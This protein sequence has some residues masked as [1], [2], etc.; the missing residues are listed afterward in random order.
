METNPRRR[1]PVGVTFQVMVS[2]IPSTY[3]QTYFF[4]FA[5]QTENVLNCLFCSGGYQINE[6]VDPPTAFWLDPYARQ[7][8]ITITALKSTKHF[9]RWGN[10]PDWD[11][12]NKTERR[13]ALGAMR[14]RKFEDN[15]RQAKVK[16]VT[17]V[18]T[19]LMFISAHLKHEGP[20]LIENV[21]SKIIP[22]CTRNNVKA[23]RSGNYM[24]DFFF[25]V[26][27]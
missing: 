22:K 3:F 23:E 15:N 6:A 27:D 7:K 21:S 25:L 18:V 9:S 5:L 20:E 11:L 1:E 10:N 2:N 13:Q 26:T 12:M 16:L 8:D 24:C 19:H 14:K 17:Y 4:I